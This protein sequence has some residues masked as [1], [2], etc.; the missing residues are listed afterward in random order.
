MSA[1]QL[2][3]A[4]LLIVLGLVGVVVAF[5]AACDAEGR[6]GRLALTVG[7]P[8]AVSI[9]AGFIWLLEQVAAHVSGGS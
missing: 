9:V 4:A 3:L 2:S 7:I 1:M 6:G 5:I 8:G